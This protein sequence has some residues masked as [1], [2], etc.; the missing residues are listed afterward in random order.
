MRVI[1][2]DKFSQQEIE[3]YR[4][5]VF[6]NIVRGLLM[7]VDALPAM[8]LQLSPTNEVGISSPGL[9][10]HAANLNTRSAS[11]I[12][13]VVLLSFEMGKLIPSSCYSRYKTYGTTQGYNKGGLEP[14][15]PRYQRSKPLLFIFSTFTDHKP[16]QPSIVCQKYNLNDVLHVL[17]LF[18]VSST[19]SQEC[20]NGTT[21]LVHRYVYSHYG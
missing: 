20:F 13:F 16:T 4:Q 18:P 21:S 2:N 5:L 9:A 7:L 19:I 15:R 3:V 12:H 11:L 1:H 17:T 14:M 6:S 10:S 8:Q